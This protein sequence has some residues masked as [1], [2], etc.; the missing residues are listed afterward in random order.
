MIL[1]LHGGNLM[2]GRKSSIGY[3]FGYPLIA[4]HCNQAGFNAVMAEQIMQRSLREAWRPLLQQDEALDTTPFNL[5]S[6]Q[7]AITKDN[8]LLIGGIHDLICPIKPIEELWES[9]GGQPNLWRL[10]HCHI[11]FMSEPGLT[12]RVLRW[13]SHG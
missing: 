10:P 6:A 7:P 2:R 13:L 8:V 3:R 5:T 1:L 11:S 9:W 4:R 12:G